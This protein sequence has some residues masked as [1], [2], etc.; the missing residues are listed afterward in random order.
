LLF[1]AY[2][3][4]SFIYAYFIPKVARLITRKGAH[5]MALTLGGIGLIA[6]KFM[7]TEVGLLICM[8]MLGIAWASIITVPYAMLAGSLPPEKMG[9][10]MGLF[11]ITV[12]LPQIIASA[13]LGLVVAYVFHNHAMGAVAFGGVLYI[14]GAICMF[15][16]KDKQIKELT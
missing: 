3:M 9:L 5:I 16:V 13:T 15:F 8:L 7:Y 2:T 1:S 4:T 12:T 11:N 14:I 10:Y 6:A